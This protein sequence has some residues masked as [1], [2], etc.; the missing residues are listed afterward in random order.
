VSHAALLALAL[1]AAPAPVPPA[2]AAA[3][4]AG[5]EE[6][7]VSFV[8]ITVEVGGEV[9]D[10]RFTDM[11]ADGRADL[12][13]AVLARHAGEAV[14]REIHIHHL[15]SDGLYPVAP[16]RVV[17]VLDDVIVYGC[18]DVRAE[19]GRELV[20]FTRSGAWSYSPQHDGYRDNI[21]RLAAQELLFQVPDPRRLSSWS[22]VVGRGAGELLLLP[23]PTHLTLWGPR[24]AGAV[25]E[26]AGNGAAPA[27]TAPAPSPAAA[28]EGDFAQRGTW[29]D[30]GNAALF[31]VRAPAT[32]VA[33]GGARVSVNTVD[34]K[35][36]FLEEPSGVFAALL[37]AEVHYRAPAIVDVDGDGL[38]DL[39]LRKDNAL[40]IALG[41]P[42]GFA[43]EWSRQEPLPP[44]LDKPD[45]DTKLEL[46]DLDGDGDTDVLARTNPER[47]RLDPVD[48]T[49]FV[50]IN[51]G[52][53]LL[54]PEAQ[55]VLRL[56]AS[57]T[58]A[59]VTD[60]DL[61][62]RPDLVITKWT[63][64]SLTELVSGFR[65]ERASYVHFAAAARGG[66]GGGASGGSGDGAGTPGPPP[67]ERKPSLRDEQTWTMES[68]E[69]ALVLRFLSGDCSGDGVADL[70]EVDL[71]GRVAIRR[72]EREGGL[73]SRGAW[74]VE[75][76]AWKRFDLGA[77]LDRLMLQELNGD[78]IA[79]IVNPG[80]RSLV[81]L[82]S[83]RAPGADR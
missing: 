35:A 38:S 76:E 29:G 41:T 23:T 39:V 52:R 62:G 14:R 24:G 32:V 71:S 69:D 67:F 34:S 55:Q 8:T 13:L 16:D 10:T 81:L 7:D 77:K 63:L 58:R 48:F 80:T 66:A 75:T 53:H 70:V 60:I 59:E 54:P 74:S 46:A 43:P 31:S 47:K 6:A 42:E 12:V 65:L 5:D 22:Y 2:A 61:D 17:P 21:R 3:A 20:F 40:H 72:L 25:P 37:E 56:A 27:G 68:V 64:P 57:D 45:T 50:L 1:A 33:G 79:D 4:A 9:L 11:N 30:P 73:F 15:G 26:V 19:P 82:L 28:L 49:Y 83:R 36:L 44:W 51:D 18:G 78:G